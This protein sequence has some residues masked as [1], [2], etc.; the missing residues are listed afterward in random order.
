MVY[1]FCNRNEMTDIF[2]YGTTSDLHVVPQYK[3]RPF[4]FD[5][6]KVGDYVTISIP[7]NRP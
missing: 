4:V 1:M 6:N 3:P 7:E 5:F 2:S